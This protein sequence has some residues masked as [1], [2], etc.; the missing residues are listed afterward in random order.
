MAAIIVVLAAAFGAYRFVIRDDSSGTPEHPIP[1]L[2]EFTAAQQQQ[3]HDIRDATARVREVSAN[4]TTHEGT[5]TREGYGD[6]IGLSFDDVT[7]REREEVQTFNIAYRLLHMTG[8]DD[9]LL[10]SAEQRS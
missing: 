3:L 2:H 1:P 4:A 7:P 10:A 6:W 5:L 9:A 8:P